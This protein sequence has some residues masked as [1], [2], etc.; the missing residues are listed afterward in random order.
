VVKSEGVV[1]KGMDL[2]ELLPHNCSRIKCS[3]RLHVNRTVSK[4]DLK[5]LLIFLASAGSIRP[6]GLCGR[7][8]LAAMLGSPVSSKAWC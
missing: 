8:N 7:S 5:Q 1:T 6:S 4:G 2:D 3:L